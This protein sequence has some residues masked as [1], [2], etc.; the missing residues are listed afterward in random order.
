[1]KKILIALLT[2]L[3][4]AAC[5][6]NK[7]ETVE[8]SPENQQEPTG[9]VAGGWTINTDLPEMNDATFDSARKLLGANY[10]PLFILG[11]QPVAGENI[12]YLCYGTVVAPGAKP[13]FKVVTV[14]KDLENEGTAEITGIQDFV[15]TDY[16]EGQGEVTPEGLMG[17]WQDTDSLPNMLN[18][19]ENEVFEKAMEGLTGVGYQPVATLATQVV[20][21]TNY[22]FLALGTTVTAQPITHLYVVN[23]Y[24]D[25]QGNATLNNICAINLST[26][27]GNK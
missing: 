20:A 26:L 14:F 10:S 23:V 12:Q 16:L 6:T 9:E 8:P 15:I 24:A 22:A 25:L 5:T 19:K 2:L 1:M 17:G 11:T 3:M 18:D 21:G 7:Q 4:L 13:E 27:V